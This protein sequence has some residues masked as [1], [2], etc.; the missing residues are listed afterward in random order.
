[1][2]WANTDVQP[3]VSQKTYDMI[4]AAEKFNQD[5]KHDKAI[6]KINQYL[7]KSDPQGYDF[8]VTQ[9]LLANTYL[10]MDKHSAAITA[11]E[12]CLTVNGYIKLQQEI[13]GQLARIYLNDRQFEKSLSH[14]Q[15]I[16]E[17]SAESPSHALE[18]ANPE[19][20]ILAGYALIQLDKYLQAQPYIVKAIQLSNQQN[21]QPKIEWLQLLSG[22]YY[23]LEDH[24]NGTITIKQIIALEPEK[25]QIYW[26][27]LAAFYLMAN[28]Q[29]LAVVATELAN[30]QVNHSSRDQYHYLSNIYR[31]NQAPRYAARLLEQAIANK[32]IKETTAEWNRIGNAWWEAREYQQAIN[33]Y[34]KALTI[35]AIKERADNRAVLNNIYTRV[36]QFYRLKN[37][38]QSAIKWLELALEQQPQPLRAE[39]Y[40]TQANCYYELNDKIQA[41]RNL[42]LAQ[43][44]TT[45]KS[46]LQRIASMR[47]RISAKRVM[48]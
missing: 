23:Q 3:A 31:I 40:F 24:Q 16:I 2:A 19:N 17:P 11:F 28:N 37:R 21:T 48:P 43:S 29:T 47:K 30:K 14:I 22:I 12:R 36:G 7:K 25:P 41:R 10:Q 20:Y 13:H 6:V 32:Q 18:E 45:E 5:G 33:C 34:Q 26:Q 9:K 27:Q 38:W 8:I 15:A 42:Q 4:V 46:L 1:M 39:T 35:T 44:E